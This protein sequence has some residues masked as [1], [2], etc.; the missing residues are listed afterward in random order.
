MSDL[1]ERHFLLSFMAPLDGEN[2]IKQYHYTIPANTT[3][4]DMRM[5]RHKIRESLR[6]SPRTLE[7]LA[8]SEIS[9]EDAKTL[10]AGTDYK[11]TF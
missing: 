8:I 3:L 9:A 2:H 4:P 11:F 10:F 1:K 5:I 6:P 7:I